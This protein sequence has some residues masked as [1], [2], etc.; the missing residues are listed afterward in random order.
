MKFGHGWKGSLTTPGLQRP[1]PGADGTTPLETLGIVMENV[2][3]SCLAK[4]SSPVLTDE[5]FQQELWMLFLLFW[6]S[7]SI[8]NHTFFSL[9]KPDHVAESI[10][11]NWSRCR[12][13]W[14]TN[15]LTPTLTLQPEP[16]RGYFTVEILIRLL[17]FKRWTFMFKERSGN[18]AMMAVK[19]LPAR[20]GYNI[21]SIPHPKC[22]SPPGSFI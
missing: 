15:Q 12:F 18:V 22:Q 8:Y 13:C 5:R 4:K 10:Q 16:K 19:W 11:F 1:A 14:F 6:N 20:E 9:C 21:A 3:C 17:A 7:S 2:F